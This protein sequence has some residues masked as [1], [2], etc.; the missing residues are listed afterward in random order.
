[1]LQDLRYAVRTLLKNP[2]FQKQMARQ[3]ATGV[4]SYLERAGLTRP[5]GQGGGGF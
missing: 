2:A 4:K 1:M 5:D 3:L